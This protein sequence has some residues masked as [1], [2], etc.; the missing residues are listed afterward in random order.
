[1][2]LG[3]V[4]D[5]VEE[6]VMAPQTEFN[7]GPITVIDL[8]DAVVLLPR[9]ARESLLGQALSADDH[10]RFVANIDDPDLATVPTRDPI[11]DRIG[12]VVVALTRTRRGLV[13]EL[14]LSK[15]GDGVPTD[16]GTSIRRKVASPAAPRMAKPNVP[17]T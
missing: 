4:A 1:M 11:A 13:S 10:L 8:G 12:A 7:V 3:K 17:L 15:T 5:Q 16:C 6:S 2:S 9:G 14:E